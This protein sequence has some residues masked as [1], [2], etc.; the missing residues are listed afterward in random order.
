MDKCIAELECD[1][2]CTETTSLGKG[3]LENI[4]PE[5]FYAGEGLE[6]LRPR[7]GEKRLA[8]YKEAP[9]PADEVWLLPLGLE[10]QRPEGVALFM[11]YPTEWLDRSGVVWTYFQ[12]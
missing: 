7:W 9:Q 10:Q 4:Y 11:G 8:P 5:G 3:Q 12:K 6:I 2:Y 1:S